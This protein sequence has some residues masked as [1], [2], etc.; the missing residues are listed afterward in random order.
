MIDIHCH[1]LPNVDDGSSSIEESIAMA[2]YAL[3][4]GIHTVVATPHALGG[5]FPNPPQK[6]KAACK[7]LAQ[8]FQSENIPLSVYPGAEVHLCPDM[9]KRIMDGEAQFL[10]ESRRYIMV[11]F[12]FQSGLHHFKAE[13]HHLCVNGILPVIAHPER[14]QTIFREKNILYELINMGCMVQLNSTSITGGFGEKIL[15]CAH[16]LIRLRLAHIIASDAHAIYHRPPELSHAVKIAEDILGN[17][18]DAMKMVDERPEKIL[19][20]DPLK[21]PVPK[22]PVKK[23]TIFGF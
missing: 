11:E 9:A 14:N 21:L 22:K 10:C 17:K 15:A 16:E 12:P 5:T 2:R 1:I 7:K 23:K 19:N 6:I 8:H 13:I 20:G 3:S 4:D 18:K